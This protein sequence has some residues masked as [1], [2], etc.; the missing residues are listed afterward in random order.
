MRRSPPE[1]AGAAGRAWRLRDCLLALVLVTLL[2]AMG[3]AVYATWRSSQSYEAASAMR[4]NDA[5][6]VLARAVEGNLRGRLRLMN[7]LASA[8]GAGS[9]ALDELQAWVERS[10]PSVG[11]TLVLESLGPQAGST[12]VGLPRAV[13]DQAVGGGRCCRTCCRPRAPPRRWR[14]SWCPCHPRG[15]QCAC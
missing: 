12:A 3:V 15:R 6:R 4:I 8:P 1:R 7:T 11:S 2:P 10:D 5:V 9:M 14:P 13:A